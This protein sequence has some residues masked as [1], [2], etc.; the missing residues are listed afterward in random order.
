MSWLIK[1]A[2]HALD[3]VMGG[4]G[5][6]HCRVMV[7]VGSAPEPRFCRSCVNSQAGSS[8][9]GSLDNVRNEQWGLAAGLLMD[10]ARDLG[11]EAFLGHDKPHV[12]TETGLWEQGHRLLRKITKSIHTPTAP[13]LPGLPAASSSS[14]THHPSTHRKPCVVWPLCTAP[15]PFTA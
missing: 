10:L 7:K 12:A 14:K 4:G 15:G 13:G 3:S 2:V 1:E 8:G 11:S 6:A 5:L 9:D